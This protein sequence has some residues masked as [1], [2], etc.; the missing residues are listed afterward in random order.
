V[1]LGRVLASARNSAVDYRLIKSE[2]ESKA[3]EGDEGP[4]W[5]P[6]GVVVR[7]SRGGRARAA[8]VPPDRM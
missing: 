1:S 4:G 7:V 8:L 6:G 3:K 5:A 2:S